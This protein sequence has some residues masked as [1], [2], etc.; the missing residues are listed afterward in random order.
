[1][2]QAV[3]GAVFGNS[4]VWKRLGSSLWTIVPWRAHNR[5]IAEAARG[6]QNN[7]DLIRFIAAG[8]VIVS[9]SFAV[10]GGFA[11]PGVGSTT[12]GTLGV[13]IFFS[14]SGFLVTKSWLAHPRLSA[15]IGKRL[16]RI[17]PGLI[18]ATLFVV[19]IV[20]PIFSSVP[21]RQYLTDPETLKY[22]GNPWLFNLAY[23]LPGVF[24]ANAFPQNVNGPIWTLPHEFLAYLGLAAAGY[25][26]FLR[27]RPHL[28][29]SFVTVLI[30]AYAFIAIFH[31]DNL[32]ILDIQLSS[33]V[34]MIMFFAMGSLLYLNRHRIVLSEPLALLATL[35]LLA[36][37]NLPG[38]F[39]LRLLAIP[40]LVIYLALLPSRYAHKF[41]QHG[42][43]SYGMYIYAWPVQ[44][45]IEA[46]AHNAIGP[47]R[48]TA[49]AF[50]VILLLA[51][52]SWHLIE[53]PAL[54]LKGRFGVTRYPLPKVESTSV[55]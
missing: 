18:G 26:G 46:L 51:A 41:G 27:K 12:L 43:F 48:M 25:L 21:L 13:Y 39:Y 1:M 15:F 50:P 42:D 44:Q 32:Y 54:Q 53:K 16:L 19:F 38:Q 8:F 9:H 55:I 4:A 17:M 28:V 35:I 40:Y 11:E 22:F 31:K 33:F 20:G 3:G 24:A 10:S 49:T 6:R 23:T 5:T 47:L 29:I 30:L 45:S 34:R 14:I 37:P 7:F 2:S 36:S 52:G